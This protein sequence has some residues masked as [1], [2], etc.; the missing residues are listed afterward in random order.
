MVAWVALALF[1]YE[2]TEDL[3]SG[4]QVK[5]VEEEQGMS[6]TTQERT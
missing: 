3:M 1:W 2:G 6:R 4:L 5:D